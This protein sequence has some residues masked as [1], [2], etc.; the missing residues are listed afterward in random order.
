MTTIED[1]IKLFSKIVFE[2]V[3]KEAEQKIIEF[4]KYSDEK[5][6]KEKQRI[7]KVE[8]EQISE[9]IKKAD[10][11]VKGLI[12]QEKS[13]A[14]E[15]QLKLK[16]SFIAQVKTELKLTLQEFIFTD[17]YE[18]FFLRTIYSLLSRG[19][20]DSYILYLSKRD[21]GEFSLKVQ[22]I[23]SEFTNIK[24]QIKE[25]N[26]DIIG[27]AILEQVDKR[28]RFDESLICS[29]NDSVFKIGKSISERV[30]NR[31]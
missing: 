22:Q 18:E 2:G 5:I 8:K 28:F 29:L 10:I 15:E 7:W 11:K 31:G 30:F 20:G 4:E 14:R 19:E 16:E 6:L 12:S 26:Q 27:G 9:A 24:I 21:I 13:I 23:S 3:Q 1:K 17:K 25:C